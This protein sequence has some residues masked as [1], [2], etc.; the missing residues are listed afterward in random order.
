MCICMYTYINCLIHFQVQVMKLQD[1]LESS[2]SYKKAEIMEKVARFRDKLK[3]VL[4]SIVVVNDKYLFGTTE[5]I[6]PITQLHIY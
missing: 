2:G 1:A 4:L 6:L 5:I 3:Q